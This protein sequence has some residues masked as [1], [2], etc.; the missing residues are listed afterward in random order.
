MKAKKRTGLILEIVV[1]I[2]SLIILLPLYF[3]VINS[4]KN[5][6]EASEGNFNFPTEFALFENMVELMDRVDVFQVFFNTVI[7]TVLAVTLILIIATS[8]AYILQRRKNKFTNIFFN[9]CLTALIF[10]F[11]AA[12]TFG[13]ISDLNLTGSLFSVVPIYAATGFS[14]SVFLITGYLKS[15]PKEL[16]EAAIVDGC[17]PV[18]LFFK[19]IFPLLQPIIAT[20]AIIQTVNIWNDFGIAIFF[21]SKTEIRTLTIATYMFRGS[22]DS[23]TEWNLIFTNLM[24]SIVPV[25]ILYLI[26]QKKII[27]GM[28]SGAVKG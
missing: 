28:T 16:D 10:P 20:V 8:T 17:N 27:S 22:I 18:Q 14:M 5:L 19:I 15:V 7:V 9:F 1:A 3:I 2:C 25:V 24:I 11:F 4:T 6:A 13:L 26:M 23:V 12:P 21:L